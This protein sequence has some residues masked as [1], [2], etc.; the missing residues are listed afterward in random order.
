MRIIAIPILI[1]LYFIP[2]PFLLLRDWCQYICVF[3]DWLFDLVGWFCSWETGYWPLPKAHD[4]P[5][6]Y[7]RSYYEGYED[8][9]SKWFKRQRE[10]GLP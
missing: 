6:P 4:N 2:L 3:F 9:D 10:K 1:I 8:A 7:T 5:L